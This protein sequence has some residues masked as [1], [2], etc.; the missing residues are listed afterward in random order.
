MAGTKLFLS[1]M[2]MFAVSSLSAMW[3]KLSE[4]ELLKDSQLVI[5]AV[6]GERIDHVPGEPHLRVFHVE[7]VFIGE[8]GI[9][10]VFFR[11][12]P[13][14][15]P[16]SSSDLIFLEGQKGIWFLKE[17]RPGSKIY[18]LDHPQRFWPVDREP[19][20]LELMEKKEP[21]SP[22]GAN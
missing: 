12:F 4:S 15:K 16:L 7:Q 17:T 3:I 2:L 21:G 6:L 11:V 8:Q 13:P 18:F 10:E 9:S 5:K 20:L 1:L 19:R 22:A 14:D